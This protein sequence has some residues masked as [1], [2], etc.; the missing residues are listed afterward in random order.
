MQQAD[1]IQLVPKASTI[2]NKVV[3]FFASL[4][5]LI[6][7]HDQSPRPDRILSNI[8]WPDSD[9]E[10]EQHSHGSCNRPVCGGYNE[11]F[12]VQYWASY[13]LR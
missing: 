8:D 13:H 7:Q 1:N 5:I 12:I 6:P 3:H 11:A 2:F 4:R 9:S 10:S